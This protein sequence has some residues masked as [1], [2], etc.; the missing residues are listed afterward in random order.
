MEGEGKRIYFNNHKLFNPQMFTDDKY[1]DF[2]DKHPEQS[3][4]CFSNVTTCSVGRVK[5]ANSNEVGSY[6]E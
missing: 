1:F 2:P 4:T 5:I 6:L 3:V